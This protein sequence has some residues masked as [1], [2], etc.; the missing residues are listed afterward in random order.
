MIPFFGKKRKKKQQ[1]QK[2]TKMKKKIMLIQILENTMNL[3]DYAQKPPLI[4]NGEDNIFTKN[5]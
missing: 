2:Q 3:V 4:K 5:V 1:K